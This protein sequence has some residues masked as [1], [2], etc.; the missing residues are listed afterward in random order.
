MPSFVEKLPLVKVQLKTTAAA[1]RSEMRTSAITIFLKSLEG[2]MKI[3]AFRHQ[4]KTT[5]THS[6]IEFS[7]SHL[8]LLKNCEPRT[9]PW[10]F[11]S[12]KF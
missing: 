8:I 6:M 1:G 4:V 11:Y 5:T 3:D 10:A 12:V 2:K 7:P 9:V